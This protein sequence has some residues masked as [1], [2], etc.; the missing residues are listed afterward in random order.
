MIE[1]ERMRLFFDMWGGRFVKKLKEHL[2]KSYAYAPGSTGSQPELKVG[3]AYSQG[4]N[5]DYSGSAPKMATSTLY[6][7]IQGNVVDEGFELY[8]AEYWEYVNYGR[9]KGFYAPP[10]SIIEWAKTKGFPNPEGIA[11]GIN[12]N[13]YKFG[14]APTFFFDNAINEL[15]AQFDEELAEQM[16]QSFETFFDNLLII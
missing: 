16:E 11:F 14:I 5:T 12:K 13:I 2:M 4:R 7:S 8:M 1:D 3:N 10:D 9:A 15:Q 6:N